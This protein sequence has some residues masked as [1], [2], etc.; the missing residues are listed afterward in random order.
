MYKVI[1]RFADL[2][3]KNHIY[4]VGDAYPRDGFEVSD[5][6]IS[7]LLGSGNKV[8]KPVIEK[9]ITKASEASN[10]KSEPVKSAKKKKTEE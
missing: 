5:E 6:R 7:E 4:E 2:T 10:K 8:G 9:L 1:I 3:D